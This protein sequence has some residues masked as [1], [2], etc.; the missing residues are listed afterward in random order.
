MLADMRYIRYIRSS[1]LK[2][3]S[4]FFI[5]SINFSVAPASKR[6]REYFRL[7]TVDVREIALPTS[8]YC[9]G[10]NMLDLICATANGSAAIGS[11]I[12]SSYMDYTARVVSNQL[13]LLNH[14]EYLRP[15]RTRQNLKWQFHMNCR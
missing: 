4:H 14:H 10:L 12:T 7:V 3:L 15:W 2:N 13:N 8:D 5:T 1:L 11:T 6:F 9:Y